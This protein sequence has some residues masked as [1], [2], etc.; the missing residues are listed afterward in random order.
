MPRTLNGPYLITTSPTMTA[1]SRCRRPMLA[2]TVA[3]LDRHVDTATL[4]PTGELAALVSGRA[5]YELHGEQLVRRGV[6]KLRM[7]HPTLPVLADH[8][9]APVPSE[10]IDAAQ[11]AAAMVLVM[12]LLGG[13]LVSDTDGPPPF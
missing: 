2:A 5:T 4:N 6:E 1:C 7:P 10:H 12:Q 8:D 11:H 9:C 3:G 13:S